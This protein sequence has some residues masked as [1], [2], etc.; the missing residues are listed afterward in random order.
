M[1]VPPAAPFLKGADVL[2]TADCVPFA[3]A[4][5]HEQYLAG[6]AVIVGCPK[7]DDI[8]YYQEKLKAIF[9]E[10]KP[11]SV[12]VVR[13]EVPCCGGIVGAAIQARNEAAP[14]MKLEVITIGIRGDELARE[15]VAA[16]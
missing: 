16:A 2:L 13:M 7:L 9:A 15:E 1:L 11:R 10:A 5:F 12:T 14:G 6:K 3:T 8:G 4:N